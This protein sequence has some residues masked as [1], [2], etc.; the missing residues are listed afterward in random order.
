[1]NPTTPSNNDNAAQPRVFG[2]GGAP[3]TP[4]TGKLWVRVMLYL[5]VSYVLLCAGIFAFQNRLVFMPTAEESLDPSAFGFSADQA[6]A[7]E[8]SSS[9]GVKLRGWHLG[10]G[11]SREGGNTRKL[12]N[13][14]LVV[15]FFT[16]NAG[17]RSHRLN[18]FQQVGSLGAHVV[19]FDYR[20]YGDSSGSP[21]EE[22][23]ARDARAAW[24]FLRAKNV[25]AERI[26]L[27][28]ESLG[29]AVAIRLASELCAEG[30]PPAGLVTEATFTQLGDVAA[31]AYWFIPARLLLR[32]TF[33]SVERM[34][35][36][37]CPILMFHGR[38]DALVPFALGQTLFNAAPEKSGSGTPKTFVEL[39]QAGHNDVPFA[40][41]QEFMQ[42]L[43]AFY[44]SLAPELKRGERP[45]TRPRTPKEMK[46]KAPPAK[47]ES[48]KRPP[49]LSPNSQKK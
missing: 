30:T 39:P 18:A 38:R 1:M 3:R 25:P 47:A 14:A 49:V 48:G 41:P 42:A 36:I 7:L 12:E 4:V 27:Q 10:G 11:K 37:T 17:N 31:H 29:G 5:V 23:L 46:V 34:P 16:G 44:E 45:H 33:P 32:S 21:S 28:G 26:V 20:G 19:C 40:Q 8:T 9:D 35:K 15:L 22:G 43:R 2:A 13:A 6:S 24:D